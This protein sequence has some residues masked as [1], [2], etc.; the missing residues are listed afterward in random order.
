MARY[1][2]YQP[3]KLLKKCLFKIR[4]R[5]CFPHAMGEMAVQYFPYK[6]DGPDDVM[7]DGQN[8]R[9]IIKPTYQHRIDAEHKVNNASIPVSHENFFWKI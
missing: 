8:D 2:S 4:L 7:N 1:V 9:M 5:D 3:L 6:V